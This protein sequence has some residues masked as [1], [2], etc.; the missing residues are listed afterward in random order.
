[1]KIRD[2]MP[3]AVSQA[4]SGLKAK[5]F[6]TAFAQAFIR[7]A[8]VEDYP[9]SRFTQ[10]YA[11]SAWVHF[12]VTQVAGE[13]ANRPVC[14]Y[15]GEQ[16]I[17]DPAFLAWWQ[18][19]ALGPKTLT[20]TQPRLGIKDVNR[21][22][23]S[24]AKLEGEFF[25]C[26]DD[27]WVLAGLKRNPAALSPFLIARPDR[28]R[29]I[30]QGGILQG[31]EYIDTAGVRTIFLPEQVIH[32]KAFNPYDDWRGLGDLQAAKVPAEGAFL[33]GV[34]I[35]ELMR[36]N[37]DQGFIVIGKN[38]VADDA[39][40]EQIVADL[41]AKRAALRAGIA[42][43][44]FL[45]GDIS[46]ERP[47]ERAASPELMAG[48][49]LTHQEILV[50]FGIPPSMGEVKAS[51]SVGKDSDY[52]QLII[53][54]CQPLGGQIAD[55]YAVIGAMMTGKNL[56]AELEWDDHPVMIE[57]R[58]SRIDSGQK[59]W[60]SGMPWDKVNVWLGLGMPAFTGW[61]IGYIPYSVSPVSPGE[62]P[63]PTVDP[64]ADPSLAELSD[65]GK[66]LPEIATLKLLVAARSRARDT[67]KK[68]LAAEIDA[69]AA[70]QCN[71]GTGCIAQKAERDPQEIARWKQHMVDRRAT[72]KAFISAFG[73]VLM[74][75]RIETLRKIES[76]EGK[77][78]I[79]DRSTPPTCQKAA[80]ADFLFNVAEF[81]TDFK[82]A[83]RKQEK[84][85]VDTA[86]QQLLKEI[87]RDDPFSFAPHDVLSFLGDRDLKLANVP[88]NIAA[89]IRASIQEGLDAGD[90][91]AQLS[92]RV[93]KEFNR[94]GDYEANRIASTE[95]SAAYGWGRNEAMV[96]AHVKFK[97]WLTSGN[98][99]VRPAHAEA[100]LTYSPDAGIPVD[101]PFIVDG[102][103]LMFPGDSSGSPGNVINCH[104]V[105]IAV[106]PP[107]DAS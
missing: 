12:A 5:V 96:K 91:Q 37:G 3:P 38:G 57:V 23:A 66:T 48:L 11:Q 36:N 85:A 17:T 16:K 9:R 33:T 44:L 107:E 73:R 77:A 90:T 53:R 71:C 76:A 1:V 64:A 99:N 49:S 21:D 31:Y 28:M 2:F 81:A 10:P 39:Q 97:G 88:E 87:G 20:G 58:N 94:L 74:K 78:V 6:S 30:V 46:V 18:A 61:D 50:A 72:M 79:A 43:D 86:A 67:E 70:F 29:L 75:A 80:A 8:D 59:L 105:Q 68:S 22:L 89:S 60:A 15:S 45:T 24:W 35:R 69:L 103:E 7:G 34:Y 84:S 54:N 62:T 106:G 32:W 13:I 14:F 47:T 65:E 52:Y 19:P 42:K 101:Q 40:R 25:L 63:S 83:M 93:K 104:C 27:T 56:T 51:Y 41:R 100:G 82:A 92:A 98:A 95:T 4:W 102:E 26:F 55:K